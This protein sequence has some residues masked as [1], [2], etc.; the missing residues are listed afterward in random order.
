MG[1]LKKTIIFSD[2]VKKVGGGW[3][4]EAAAALVTLLDFSKAFDRQNA[5]L[6]VKSFQD[7]GVRPSLI[8]FFE[9]RKMTV[10][11]HGIKSDLRDLPGL[12]ELM[13]EPKNK[14]YE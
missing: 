5:T 4:G 13:S 2:I 9:G 6:A 11:W 12:P 3:G 8:S 10:K 1:R 7:N 14:Q